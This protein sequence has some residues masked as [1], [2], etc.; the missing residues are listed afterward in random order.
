MDNCIYNML[1]GI[2]IHLKKTLIQTTSIATW[3]DPFSSFLVQSLELRTH[4]LKKFN[5]DLI[6]LHEQCMRVSIVYDTL[7]LPVSVSLDGLIANQGFGT[8]SRSTI[9]QQQSD[10]GVWVTSLR[11]VAIAQKFHT[12]ACG[13]QSR[14][15][16]SQSFIM[17]EPTVA[18]SGNTGNRTRIHRICE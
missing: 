17:W 1:S 7:N 15:P 10:K 5:N 16:R 8:S 9:A 2:L 4:S 14:P 3:T 18:T 11:E 12:V 13:P 6:A